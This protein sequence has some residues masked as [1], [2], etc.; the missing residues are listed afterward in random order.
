MAD[1]TAQQAAIKRATTAAQR[2]MDRLDADGLA[3][4]EEIYRQAAQE[5][6]DRIANHAGADGAVA[7]P[8]LQDLLS[9]VN[10]QLQQLSRQRDALL[11]GTAAQ[12]ASLGVEP[13]AAAIGVTASQ[14]I[15][16]E[17]LSFVRTFV[18]ED[19]L[20]LSD[21]I[22]RLDRH[23]R[24]AVAGAIE[25]AVI[26][27]HGAAQAAREFLS[28]GEAVPGEVITKMGD[29]DARKIAKE[30]GGALFTGEGN[31]MDNALR[32]FRT[33]INRA[34]GEA[35]IKGA[36]EHPDAAGVRFLLSPSHPK[37]DIC[38]FHS[39]ANLHGLGPGVYPSRAKCPWPAHPNTLSYVEV[40]FKDEITAEDRAGRETP[41]DAL[42]RLTPAQR[43]GALGV[44]KARVFNDGKLTTGMIKAPWRAVKRRVGA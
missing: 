8:A 26:Q 13:L 18:A 44:N 10:A 27:G 2:A 6:R 23:A 3:Q 38:D 32:L 1:R 30:A 29:S 34:H 14:R 22:W 20:Q 28:R 37:P 9:Q 17:A 36:L 24:E 16:S 41:L 4:L 5:I 15:A 40:V 33:E 31:P 42:D 12:A 11:N 43:I 19:G 35:Y 21:R 39:R 7:L 25:Q